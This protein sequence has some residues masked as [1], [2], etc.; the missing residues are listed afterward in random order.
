MNLKALEKALETLEFLSEHEGAAEDIENAK[1][2]RME[3][4]ALKESIQI[5]GSAGCWTIL[6]EKCRGSRVEREA[7][8]LLKAICTEAE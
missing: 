5:L 4:A 3:L 2:A 6:E 7:V 1:E 8:A